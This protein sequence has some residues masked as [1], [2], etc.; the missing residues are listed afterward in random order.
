VPEQARLAYLTEKS[1][2]LLG[3]ISLA[4]LALTLRTQKSGVRQDDAANGR[5]A[6]TRD[7]GRSHTSHRMAQQN[8]SGKS[9][10]LDEPNDIACVI[11]VSIPMERRAG[12]PV[13]SSVGHNYIVFTFESACQ[14]CPA[15]S[16]ACQTVKQNQWGFGPAS[17]QIMDVDAVCFADSGHTVRD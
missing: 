7:H 8:W 6:L 10:P 17:S 13:P 9:E 16:A 2:V 12:I 1:A 4:H 5:G 15:G 14:R 11:L 3:R